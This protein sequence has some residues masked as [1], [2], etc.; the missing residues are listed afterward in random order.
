MPIAVL[1]VYDSPAMAVTTKSVP[2]ASALPANAGRTALA[3][4]ENEWAALKGEAARS[5]ERLAGLRAKDTTGLIDR[6][7]ASTQ[8]FAEAD[9]KA[10]AA[11]HAYAEARRTADAAEKAERDAR[12]KRS[13]ALRKCADDIIAAGKSANFAVGGIADALYGAAAG[14]S[15]HP[16]GDF[17]DLF[18]EVRSKVDVE[19]EARSDAAFHAGAEAEAAARETDA[20]RAELAAIRARGEN[21][22][23]V[24]GFEEVRAEIRSQM[25]GARS[26]Y[27]LVEPASGFWVLLFSNRVYPTRANEKLFPFRRALHG[28]S[29]ERFEAVRN[30]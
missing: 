24:A 12:A 10:V 19:R 28:D 26:V 4:A 29:W 5:R 18:A 25:L 16:V 13:V 22:P 6:E 1:F 11:E 21:F 3:A 9:R 2:S 23:E 17:S 15:R 8:R 27:E 20:R 30:G 14:D 7:K